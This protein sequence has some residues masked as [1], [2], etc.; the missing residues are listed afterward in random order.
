[1]FF[2]FEYNSTINCSLIF[3][4]ICVLSGIDTKAPSILS[5]FQDIHSYTDELLDNAFSIEEIVFDFSRTPMTSPA[6][7]ILE[8]ILQSTP[9][10]VMCL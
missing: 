10:T 2:Y 8:G 4:G 9:S 3:S 5:L 6:L 1:M 7:I